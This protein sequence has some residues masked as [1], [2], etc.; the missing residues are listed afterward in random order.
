MGRQLVAPAMVGAI[1]MRSASI[2]FRFSS[3][4][5]ACEQARRLKGEGL[6]GVVVGPTER[7][8]DDALR[9]A[10]STLPLIVNRSLTRD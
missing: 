1:F 5:S 2:R 4:Q 7:F 3:P 8:G 10:F 6:V 9:E